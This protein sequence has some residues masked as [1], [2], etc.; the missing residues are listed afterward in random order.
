MDHAPAGGDPAGREDEGEGE[1]EL[2]EMPPL[3]PEQRG[4]RER[5]QQIQAAEDQQRHSVQVDRLTLS[6]HWALMIIRSRMRGFPRGTASLP[7]C[8]DGPD[9]L[10]RALGRRFTVT[11]LGDAN[12]GFAYLAFA[13][14]G[15]HSGKACRTDPPERQAFSVCAF[16][17]GVRQAGGAGLPPASRR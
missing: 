3:A 7:G 13:G 1:L 5:G 12:R 15:E 9:G 8:K 17:T 11:A 10:L 2:A 16:L 4:E 6:A 14:R